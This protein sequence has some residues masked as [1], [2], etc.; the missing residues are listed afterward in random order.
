MSWIHI[1][2]VHEVPVEDHEADHS[3]R[4][5]RGYPQLPLSKHGVGE[6]CPHVVV[7]VDHRGNGRNGGATRPKVDLCRCAD[8][9]A[10]GPPD[11]DNSL[12]RGAWRSVE[13][14]AHDHTQGGVEPELPVTLARRPLDL[15]KDRQILVPDSTHHLR[16]QTRLAR[17]RFRTR[18]EAPRSG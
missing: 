15:P 9:L 10:F 17:Q 3:A 4:A 1:E 18:A 8:I 16:H 5:M 13:I 7:T 14:S 11:E 6:P 12:A 2:L